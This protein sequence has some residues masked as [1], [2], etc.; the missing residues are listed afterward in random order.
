MKYYCGLDVSLNSTAACVVNQNGD[1]IREAMIPSEPTAIDEWLRKLSLPMERIGLE[2]GMLSPWLCTELLGL[3]WPAICI[4]SRHAKA[5][6]AAQRVKTDRNDARGIAHIM[7]TGW[8][9]AVH[10]KSQQSHKLRILLANR[11]FLMNKRM[12]IDA[13]IRGTIK[14]FG[15]KVG[16]VAMGGYEARIRELT[17]GMDELQSYVLP[18]L[19]VRRHLILQSAKLEKLIRTFVKEDTICR[20]LMTVPGIGPLTALAFKTFVDRPERFSKSSAVGAALAGC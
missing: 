15:L 6:M 18:M 2:A 5:A 20:R 1:I 13:Q 16:K 19:E 7:R 17:D 3:D 4:E 14:V 11:R 12:T 9:R 8:F 10:V